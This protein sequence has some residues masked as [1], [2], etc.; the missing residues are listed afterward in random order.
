MAKKVFGSF[1]ILLISFVIFTYFISGAYK[2]VEAEKTTVPKLQLFYVENIGPYHKIMDNLSY[3]E[4]EFKKL[5]TPCVRTFGH[6]L[7]DPEV[8]K[9]EKM[10]SHVGCA[11]TPEESPQLF[12]LP[13]RVKEKFFSAAERTDRVCFKGNFKGSPA[14]SAIKVY[15]VLK[16][17]ADANKVKLSKDY[18]EVYTVDGDN[19]L[20]DVYLCAE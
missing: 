17:M 16:E 14:L 19:V 5:G 18:L 3:V 12:T 7:S 9:H 8:I 20:T 2:S 6:F 11:F 13:D 4:E 1:L 10:I 15:P